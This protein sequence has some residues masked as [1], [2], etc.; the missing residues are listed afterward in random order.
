MNAR[1]DT[2]DLR[3][4]STGLRNIV[5]P[6]LLLAALPAVMA[7]QE[8]PPAEKWKV[9][10]ELSYVVTGGNSPVSTFSLA[11]T[12]SKKW[13]K[14]A[15]IFKTYIL[16]GNSTTTT[17]TAVGTPDE[18]VIDEQKT[19]KLVA[20]NYVLSGQ[21]DRTLSRAVTAQVSFN[22][23]RNKFSGIASRFVLTAGTG[24]PIIQ[25][26]NT[27]LKTDTSLTFTLRKYVADITR[28]FAGFRIVT[29]FEQKFSAQA[30]YLTSILFDDNLKRT[31]DW[32]LDWANIVSAPISKSLSLKTSLRTV[33]AHSPA[34]R[35]IELFDSIGDDLGE[36][37]SIPLKKLDV[38][39]TNSLVISF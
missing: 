2:S 4:R 3:V 10:T 24:F 22:W 34:T 29:A 39:F 38:Y 23:D 21:Y 35:A 28:S 27:T 12:A 18:Y 33:Y 8:Q 25:Q 5:I 36:T 6:I 9:S 16:R 32:R 14:N 19:T 11:N 15:V 30:A 37:V 13:D 7:A 1:P 20:E 26:K 17:M 31:V